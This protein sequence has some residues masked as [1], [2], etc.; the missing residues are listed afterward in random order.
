M[1]SFKNLID[2]NRS[3]E[4][5]VFIQIS[6]AMAHLIKRGTLAQRYKLP[7]S[8]SLSEGLG[9]HRKTVIA[10]YEELMSQG[11]IEVQPSKGTFVSSKL[12]MIEPQSISVNGSIISPKGKAAF[13]YSKRA[14]L[15]RKDVAIEEMLT[16]DEGIPDVRIA[17]VQEILRHS[18]NILAR[19][20]NLKHLSYGSV[21]GDSML[22]SVLADYLHETR[23]LNITADNVL[24]TRGSQM[25]MYLATQLIIN[26][27]D[28]VVVGETNYWTANLTLKDRGAQLL[29]VPVD[30]A[31]VDT[32]AIELL[33]K[34]KKIKA[35]YVTPHHHHPTTV[36]LSAKRRVHLVQ[37]A[38]QYNFAILED[39]YDYDFHYQ[40]APLLPLASADTNHV[41][42]MGAICKI[43]A[44]AYR[45]GY[46]VASKDFIEEVSYLRRIIDRQG[47]PV[48]ERAIANMIKQGD[49]QRHTKKALKL[50]TERRENFDSLLLKHL[51]PFVT[52]QIP[53][54]GM[55]FWIGLNKKYDWELIRTECLK[56]HLRIPDAAPYDP[57]SI[58]HNHNRMGFASLNF[59]EQEKAILILKS[60]INGFK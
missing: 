41:V 54:G 39:D 51:A 25:A 55:A 58:G 28:L 12:P 30:D 16:V 13:N 21:K 10:A 11:W 22:R 4:V 5:P 48:L 19:E 18:K 7:G 49:I 44:P 35:I 53:E 42:Y 60:V 36:T 29:T 32:D 9:V 26:K 52:Y 24:I 20:Y 27:D 46:M 43:V 37:L 38:A 8:R 33:C 2:I 56:K 23:G 1:I 40:R 59:E 31:G 34:K 14:L 47:D 50:Y 15:K 45:V 3:S 6:N 57:F 17:P